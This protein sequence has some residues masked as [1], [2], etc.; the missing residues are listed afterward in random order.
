[1]LYSICSTQ[2]FE[3]NMKTESLQSEYTYEN[4]LSSKTSDKIPTSFW[5]Y[6]HF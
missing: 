5:M 6:K 2:K 4:K 1:M 3:A